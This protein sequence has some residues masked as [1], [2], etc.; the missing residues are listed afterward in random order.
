MFVYISFVAF[1][2][3]DLKYC[4]GY[5]GIHFVVSD[6]EKRSVSKSDS[7]LG[8]TEELGLQ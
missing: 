4:Y 7:E 1:L 5:F 2:V 6:L 3:I 8:V